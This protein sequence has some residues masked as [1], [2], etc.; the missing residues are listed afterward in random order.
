MCAA[1][2]RIPEP[3]R[4]PSWVSGQSREGPPDREGAIAITTMSIGPTS[5]DDG[6][7]YGGTTQIGTPVPTQ[8]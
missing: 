6:N 1:M 7:D 5:M 3:E 8:I 4:V 2:R